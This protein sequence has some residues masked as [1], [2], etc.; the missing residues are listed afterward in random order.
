MIKRK[1]ASFSLFTRGV[2][3]TRARK[4]EPRAVASSRARS[5]RAARERVRDTVDDDAI[6]FT[7]APTYLKSTC[8]WIK[9][10]RN[11][12]PTQRDAR[13]I[14]NEVVYVLTSHFLL[15]NVLSTLDASVSANA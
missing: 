12:M 10:T 13:A 14:R 1:R 9:Y 11:L 3:E 8:L 4:G 15:R 5:R 2:L 7:R 6:A